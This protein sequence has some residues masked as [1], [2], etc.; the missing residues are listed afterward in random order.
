MCDG[1]HGYMDRQAGDMAGVRS[2][3]HSHRRRS[4]EFGDR[5]RGL[6]CSI[7]SVGRSVGS[8]NAQIVAGALLVALGL[9]VF[10]FF[11]G[12]GEPP[13]EHR[14]VW[15]AEKTTRAPAGIPAQIRDRIQDLAGTGVGTLIVYGVGSRSAHVASMDLGVT[16]D[17]APESDPTLRKAAMSKR[18]DTVED[19]VANSSVGESGFSLFAALQA[20]ADESARSDGRLEVW[21]STTVL[22]ASTDPLK[23]PQLTV[24]D[25]QRAAEEL[26]A[27]SLGELDLSRVDLHTI[28][29]TPAGKDQEALNPA[30]EEW[31]KAFVEHLMRGLHAHVAPLLHG[32]STKPA[33]AHSSEVPRV[34]P[35]PDPTPRLLTGQPESAPFP[36][37]R[38]DT[39]AF[40]P[41]TATLRN[42]AAALAAVKRIV[43][44]FMRGGRT[45]VVKVTGYCAAVG[46]QA[47]AR[48]LSSQRAE[49][50][51][52]LLEGVPRTAMKIHG[53]GYD[54]LADPQ[55]P[56][57][58]AA[59]RVV[60]VRYSP[61]D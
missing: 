7:G 31:R 55:S 1:H 59:Q 25:P 2:A 61:S 6:R 60:V 3:R 38:I 50:I 32:T 46:D 28:L 51:S 5:R 29:L 18:L 37:I 23:V 52:E 48:R 36:E 27:G 39:V 30:S 54:E 56:P 22:T 8:R 19:A 44:A 9:V 11:L 20:A 43:D 35:L 45:G 13:P 21:L 42:P 33:W 58:S 14:L 12:V 41:D 57:I 53:L 34:I 17:G 26:L 47:G 49:V 15:I 24:A 40:F 10:A 4:R 16:R